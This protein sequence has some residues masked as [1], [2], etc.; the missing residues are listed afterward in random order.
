MT[1]AEPVI[2]WS[3][4]RAGEAFAPV[5]WVLDDHWVDAYLAASGEDHP[6]FREGGFAPPLCMSLVRFV[7]A[8]LGGRWPPGT[9]QLAEQWR[10]ARSLRRGERVA[11]ALRV[12]AV[13]QWDG[14][15]HLRFSGTVADRQ[16]AVACEQSMTLLWPDTVDAA[17]HL[18]AAPRSPASETGPPPGAGRHGPVS[19]RFPLSRVRAYADLAAA[20]DPIHV[21]PDFARATLLGCNIVQGKLVMTL[22]SRTMLAVAGPDW[23]DQGLLDVRFRR[24]VRVDEPIGAWAQASEAGGYA[25]WCENARGQRVIEGTAGVRA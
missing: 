1:P 20:N 12:D 19:D 14:R 18:P 15:P 3:R 23:L 9:L 2:D 13:E 11:F 5:S 17:A 24:P 7:K 8:S 4:L 10:A 22:L 25:V 6:L 21:D 16:G